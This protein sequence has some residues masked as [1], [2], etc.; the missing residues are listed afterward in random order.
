[1]HIFTGVAD[2]HLTIKSWRLNA[3]LSDGWH[4]RPKKRIF[5]GI[6]LRFQLIG[7]E[8]F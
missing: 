3:G 5:D 1:M 7:V 2:I 4:S 8:Y 6:E